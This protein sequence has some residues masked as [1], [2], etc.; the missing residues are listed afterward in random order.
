MK[1]RARRTLWSVV[2]RVALLATACG[3]L[4]CGSTTT[5]VTAPS[6]EK[7][8]ISV[9]N[10]PSELPAS[11]GTGTLTV[12]TSRDCTWSASTDAPW[13]SLAAT[14]G[15]GAATVNYSVLPNPN[16]TPRRSQI[17]IA[18]HNVDVAQAPAPCRYDVSPTTVTV[19]AAEHQVAVTV[20]A[21]AGCAWTARSEVPWIGRPAP[22]DG[23]VSATVRFTAAANATDARTGTV[24]VANATVRVNQAAGS[25]GN[26]TTQPPAPS[27]TPTP[28]PTPTCTYDVTP[29][30]ASIAAAGDQVA[31]A[32]TA[33][34]GC[35]WSASSTVSWITIASGG[36]GSGSGSVRVSV[37][38]NN[39]ASA[40]TGMISVAG[41][42]VTIEQQAAAQLCSYRLTPASRD[43]GP[44]PDAF[45]V[46]VN[47][48]SGCTWT[49]SSDVPWI[50]IAGGGS[51]SGAGSLRV[52]IT[53]NPGGPRSGT[54]RVATETL[55]VQQAGACTY[56]IKPNDYHAGR[57]PDTIGIDVSATSGCAWTAVTDAPWVTI[58]AG[59]SGVG[60][61]AVRLEI[62]ANSGPAR[63]A[64]V[65][66]A[67]KPFTLL[68]NGCAPTI[69]PGRYDAG[70]G[71][72]DVQIRVNAE[73]GCTWTA[74]STVSWVS[75][76]DGGSGSGD[77]IVR[78]FVQPNSGAPRAVTLTIAGQ[79]FALTQKGGQ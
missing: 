35:A 25:S 68:Q 26:P 33:P 29:A 38:T 40:R 44:D 19:D 70:R 66:I 8:E 10:N 36:A 31:V 1:M 45:A 57:G 54:V 7:C 22:A 67:G 46:D 53:G 69:K 13:V 50:S 75:V 55:T 2:C 28:I 14:S 27:P 11:G 56:T 21:P 72:D 59:S 52:A 18:Q 43:V 61:G 79:P 16:G 30:R 65:T 62:P 63:T 78:L 71:P 17:V 47:A 24:L 60:N 49:G 76:T 12:A 20:T 58:A 3:A 64:V 4:G 42:S 51:G 23:T 77:G 48:P 37:S 34:T 32:V 9:T 6:G 5:S 39:G 73:P 41:Q 74:A 15:Q